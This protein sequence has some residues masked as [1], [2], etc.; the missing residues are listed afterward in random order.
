MFG[1]RSEYV[2]KAAKELLYLNLEQYFILSKN[3]VPYGVYA[4]EFELA[5]QVEEPLVKV[6]YKLPVSTSY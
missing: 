2:Q 4:Q 5:P 3:V 6:Q 1:V